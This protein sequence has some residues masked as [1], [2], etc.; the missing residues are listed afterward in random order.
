MLARSSVEATVTL[1]SDREI[2]FTSIL[3]HPRSLVFEAWT[4]PEHLRQWSCCEGGTLPV[5][6][7]ELRV[8]SASTSM[9]R[10]WRVGGEADDLF[11][12]CWKL[13]GGVQVLR[14]ASRRQGGHDDDSRSGPR[15]DPG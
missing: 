8:G 9:L 1:P 7:I 13:R 15:S 11:E 14:K 6:E 2:R 4:K 3:Q 12:L 10:R 5:C